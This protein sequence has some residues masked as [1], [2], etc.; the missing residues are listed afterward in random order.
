VNTSHMSK[1]GYWLGIWKLKVPQKIK[2]L[3]WRMCCG[4]LLM[5]IRLQDKGVQFPI[6]CVSYDHTME[7]LSDV[8]FFSCPFVVQVW[9]LAGLWEVFSH[10][11]STNGLATHAIFSFLQSL[12]ADL[13]HKMMAIIW[14]LWKHHNIKLWQTENE[15]YAQVLGR[16]H[17]LMID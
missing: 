4:C 14:S 1:P 15:V 13:R 8:F 7:D 5:R 2:S 16:A 3:I 9:H 11:V 12:A 10:V 17:K 6:S